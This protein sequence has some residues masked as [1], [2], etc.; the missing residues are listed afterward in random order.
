ARFPAQ[1]L[2]AIGG[3]NTDNA[4]ELI[5]AGADRVAICHALFHASDTTAYVQQLTPQTLTPR[6]PAKD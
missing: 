1:T 4:A 3:I 2:V 5:A 6:T